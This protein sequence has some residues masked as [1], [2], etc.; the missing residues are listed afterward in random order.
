M[1]RAWLR[2]FNAVGLQLRPQAA[3]LVTHYLSTCGGEDPHA[4]AEALVEHTKNHLRQRGGV[5]EAFIDQDIIQS[6]LNTILEASKEAESGDAQLVATH[7]I[8]SAE[9]GDGTSVYNVFRDVSLLDYNRASKQWT[10][11]PQRPRLFPGCDT[12]PRIY[13]DRYHLLLQRLLLEGKVVIDAEAATGALLPGQRVLTPVESLVGN[14]GWKLT[15]GLMSRVHDDSNVCRW[16]IEDLHKVYPVELEVCESD[17]LMTDGSFVLAEGELNGDK[18]RIHSLEVP[19]AVGRDTTRE[20]DLLPP[21]TFGGDLSEELLEALASLEP[22]H[23]DGMFVVLSEVHLDNPRVIERLDDLF[24][25]YEGSS[26]PV[27]YVIMGSFCSS[28]FMPSAEGVSSYRDGFE[29][30]K[31]MMRKLTNHVQNGTRFIF[32]PG[33]KDPGAQTLPRM[34]LTNFLT[35]DLAKEIPNVVMGSNPCRVR[36]FSRELVFFRHDVLRL[37]RQHE[38]V[39]LREPGT[40]GAPSSEHVRNE[41]VRFLADQAH[42]V[43]LPLEGSNILWAYD[44][45]MRLYPLPHAVFIGGVIEPF[46]CNY[47]DATFCSVGPFHRDASFYA[48]YPVKNVLEPCD[49]PDRGG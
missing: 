15:F 24:Q 22:A 48:Y 32:V 2:E 30:L 23:A 28:T 29:R 1:Q 17:H 25:G 3:K 5:V 33:P 43:P 16:V 47:L 21:Q 18:F 46:D 45:A 34:P 26:P 4:A 20:K 39:P 12:K 35:S 38:L 9:L 27:A 41:M 13:R 40:G 49:V 19:D 11:S 42:L 10:L 8:E 36:H 31:F 44:F 6:V 37:L 14:P 7:S